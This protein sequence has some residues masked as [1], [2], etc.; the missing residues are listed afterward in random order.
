VKHLSFEKGQS[1]VE[2]LVAIAF[3][4]ILLPAL[5]TGF[6]S[7]RE[8]KAQQNQRLLAMPLLREAQDAT[9]VVREKNW[10]TFA[11]N[12][13]FYPVISGN[14]W[15][16]AA[17]T[18]TVNGFIRSIVIS[19][20]SPLDPSTKKVVATVSWST[21]RTSMVSSTTYL[22]RYSGNTT[23]VQTTT[24]D[25]N[26]GVKNGTTVTSTSGGE[27]TLGPGG[28]ADWCQP[29]NAL[30][31]TLT[32]PKQGNV[33]AATQSAAFIG[34]G[35]GTSGV[36]FAKIAITDP[37]PPATPSASLAGT[38][39][40][41]DKTNGIF[42][43]G[44]Y[45]YLAADGSS[46]QVVILDISQLPYT[47]I[48][49]IDIPSAKPANGVFVTNNIAY[50]TSDNKLYTYNV[51]NRTGAHTTPLGQI[52]MWLG[53]GAAP[54]A[55]QV[56]VVGSYAYVGTANTLFGLQRFKVTN[57]GATLKLVGV[58][59]LTW[60]QA[61]QGLFVNQTGLR[62][63]IA[64]N[65][66]AGFFP[67]GFFIIDTSLPD[68]PVWWP[69]PNFY[70]IVG[71][72]N[73]GSTDPKGMTV[74]PGN[75][76]IVVGSGG[77][78][79]YQVVDIAN[80]SHPVS[81]GGLSI[82]QGVTGIASVL[83]QDSDAYSYIVTG[84]ASDQ[85]K[86]IQGGPGG[87][88]YATSGTFESSALDATSSAAFNRF[89]ATVS[90]PASTT[91]QFQVGVTNAINNSCSAAAYAFVG[92]DA[93]A[94]SYFTNGGIIPLVTNGNYV[95]PSRCFKYKAYLSTTDQSKTPTLYGVTVNYS[96]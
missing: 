50:V 70:S 3:A 91:I 74:V 60:Q 40:S 15:A 20:V 81:C 21:P 42:Q 96:P 57:N 61:S 88:N 41:G 84:E 13:T 18:E 83:E 24:T 49:W 33:I 64:F 46:S 8:G 25:F 19:D 5:L 12:G 52:S 48:G 16:L 23:F 78:Q 63:Y 56:I 44:S 39:S 54:L 76:A 29:Q 62:A 14:T 11:V 89:D 90:Q 31:S 7:S 34:T 27:V 85:F 87:G 51:T 95:N 38:Y 32:L 79:Q 55:K 2:L 43:E 22:T 59:N 1:L 30:V 47:K 17:G 26:G 45:V 73:V 67:K 10:S 71:T 69:F 82:S 86:I 36:T 66:G 93:S 75:K 72:Y 35:D 80:E 28:L 94:S 77:T 53:I 68:P 92:P 37:L 58:S 6:V 65:N 4:A 9:R